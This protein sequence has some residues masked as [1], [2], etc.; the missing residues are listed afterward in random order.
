MVTGSK[1]KWDQRYRE[2]QFDPNIE[3]LSFL[4][5]KL[6]PSIGDR[7]LCIAAGN[8]RNAVYL[9]QKGFQVDAI[10]ISEEGL[11]IC[12]R[13]AESRGVHINPIQADLLDYE[14]GQ[15][16][17]DL[18]TKFFYYQPDLFEPIAHSLRPGGHFMFQ[19]FSRDQL[20][21]ST[22]PRNANHLAIADDILPHFFGLRLRFYED[23]ILETEATRCG[24]R[25]AV[26]RFIAE[27]QL[28]G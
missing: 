4:K 17:Y 16:R 3:P 2:Q 11:R 28:L 19:T 8:G 21:L 24:N 14:L 20:A 22:G 13:L 12:V 23:L 15:D 1:N 5:E 18:V 7:A 10:D 25:K 26:I 9:A 6:D 27:N